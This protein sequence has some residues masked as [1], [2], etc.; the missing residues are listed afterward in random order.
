MGRADTTILKHLIDSQL[1]AI[2]RHQV[3]ILFVCQM[4]LP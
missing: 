4:L 3:L 1:V 2:V